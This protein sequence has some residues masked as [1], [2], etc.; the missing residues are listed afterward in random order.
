M[1]K[2]TAVMALL[3]ICGMIFVI[4]GTPQGGTKSADPSILLQA[5][6]AF[7]RARAEH[8]AEGFASFLADDIV[9][10]RPNQPLVRGK[11]DFLAGWNYS[12]EMSVR[13]KPEFARI[14]DDAT[15][16]FTTGSYKATLAENGAPKVAA[17]GRYITIWARQLDGS[18]KAVFD[19]G[20]QDKAPAPPA[21]A[22]AETKKP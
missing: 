21:P 14:S 6:E 7:D 4:V 5:D 8:G 12:P 1:A 9:T 13:W 10:I 19:S 17:T 2:R 11:K 22:S 20:V 3:L 16:G 18:W 15:M